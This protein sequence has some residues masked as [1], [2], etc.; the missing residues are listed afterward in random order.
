MTIY[1]GDGDA[2]DS[3]IGRRELDDAMPIDDSL[4][5]GERDEEEE[6]DDDD[7]GIVIE[8]SS[9]SFLVRRNGMEAGHGRRS[10]AST[11]MVSPDPSLQTHTPPASGRHHVPYSLA[12]SINGTFLLYMG[13][14]VRYGPS[15]M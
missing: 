1:E 7:D 5:C 15:T 2:F 10:L 12:I 6:D 8:Q 14:P 3:I 9:S 4:H 13:L 11:H